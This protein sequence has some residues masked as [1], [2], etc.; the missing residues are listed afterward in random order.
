M[1][2]VEKLPGNHEKNYE[3]KEM[4]NPVPITR[5][6]TTG[7]MVSACLFFMASGVSAA[8]N[9]HD[10][11]VEVLIRKGILTEQEALEIEKEA[12]I[13]QEQRKQEVAAEAKQKAVPKALKG[14][15]FRMRSYLD[16]S[17][18]NHPEPDDG[19]SGYNRFAITRGYFRV[20]KTMTPWL[21]AHITTDVHQ[22]S[23]GDWMVRLKYM[24]AQFTP[25]DLGFFTNMK[26]EIGMSHI[27]WLDFEEH[28]N[29]Y[30]CQ[31]TMAIERAGT[32]N[33]AD[34]GVSIRGNFG[35]KL[36]NAE[37]LLGN[38]HYNGRWG[39]WHI[40]VYNGSGYHDK[41]DNP[42]K[43][44]EA[45]LTFRPFPDSFPG[46]QIS[47][48]GLTG[49][50]N[51]RTEYGNY[52]DYQ[53]YIGMLSY[54]SPRIIMT[55]QYITTQGN[56]D[57][58]WYDDTG[59]ALWTQGVSLFANYKPPIGA[60]FPLLDKKFN[61]FCRYDWMDRDKNDK[62]ADDTAYNM[63]IMGAAWEVF[64]GN[65]ILM[66]YEWTKYGSDFGAKKSSIPDP[67]RNN[68]NEDKFQMVYQLKF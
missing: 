25:S 61:L 24:Y 9:V 39:S 51:E 1:Y 6:F 60:F 53:A 65:Y 43:P 12:E 44:F 52:P 10:P 40:G 15:K 36:E 33:S 2:T 22:N 37:A 27:P 42:N 50:G 26:S 41:E 66:D 56:K 21:G 46:L 63:Y 11:L 48:F 35:G 28:L 7:I 8:S 23:D 45:R 5:K 13:L 49:G 58:S 38:H 67:G 30:R 16:Y 64:K 62:I 47:G 31:G 18:G 14:M 55:S 54:Q 29:P 4:K 20:D 3:E 59:K 34:L 32:F 19:Q 57:G 17:V 68:G